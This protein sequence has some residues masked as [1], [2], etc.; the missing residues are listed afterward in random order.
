MKT[1]Y[2]T[3]GPGTGCRRQPVLELSYLDFRS[4][5]QVW[6]TENTRLGSRSKQ[7]Q[8]RFRHLQFQVRYLEQG[9]DL[10][11]PNAGLFTYCTGRYIH[12]S[13]CICREEGPQDAVRFSEMF[14]ATNK[15]YGAV[16]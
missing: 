8:Y 9:H 16:I 10:F 12:S 3:L 11:F 5:Q 1:L 13:Y 15:L 6:G 2:L 7:P 4:A 14:L